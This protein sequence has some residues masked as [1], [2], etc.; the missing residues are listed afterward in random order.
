MV[1]IVQDA[2]DGDGKNK[3]LDLE[4]GAK[5]LDA[6]ELEY[7]RYGDT[8]FEVFFTGGRL[9][10]GAALAEGGARLKH[11]VREGVAPVCV[12]RETGSSRRDTQQL[13]RMRVHT[14]LHAYTRTP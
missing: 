11:N 4:S 3:D 2:S 7:S 9:A 10:T 12:N 6:A 8:L 13:T 14:H 1:H 5:A